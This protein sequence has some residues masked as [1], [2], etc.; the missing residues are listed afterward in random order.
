M[1]E[2]EQSQF[3]VLRLQ[4]QELPHISRRNGEFQVIAGIEDREEYSIIVDYCNK[5]AR[6]NSYTVNAVKSS[7]IFKQHRYW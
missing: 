6:M 5:K 1:S 3:I 7:K 4:S 2:S